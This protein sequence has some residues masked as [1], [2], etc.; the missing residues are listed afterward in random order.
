MT[1]FMQKCPAYYNEERTLLFLFEQTRTDRGSFIKSGR[2]KELMFFN[3]FTIYVGYF[4]LNPSP[5][6]LICA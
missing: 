2:R 4:R 1:T 5:L 3:C 6:K